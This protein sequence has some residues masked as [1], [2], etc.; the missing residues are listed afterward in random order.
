MRLK[1]EGVSV[2]R[3]FFTQRSVQ[4]EYAQQHPAADGIDVNCILSWRVREDAVMVDTL[5]WF[6]THGAGKAGQKR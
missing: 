5:G 6:S 4:D 3:P 2:D 1:S